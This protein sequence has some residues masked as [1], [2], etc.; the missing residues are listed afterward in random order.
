MVKNLFVCFAFCLSSAPPF[1]SNTRIE[2]TASNIVQLWNAK[3]V[4][5][6][7]EKYE[8]KTF[9]VTASLL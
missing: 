5:G 3:S 6:E 2:Y 7:E 4:F 8:T 9:V 1:I